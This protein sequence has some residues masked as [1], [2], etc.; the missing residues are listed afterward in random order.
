MKNE[1]KLLYIISG[2]MFILSVSLIMSGC[3]GDATVIPSITPTPTNVPVNTATPVPTSVV[4]TPTPVVIPDISSHFSSNA[5]YD[6]FTDPNTGLR[7]G[8][9]LIQLIQKSS[10]NLSPITEVDIQQE[11][12]PDFVFFG[13]VIIQDG[14]SDLPS[15]WLTTATSSLFEWKGNT[16]LTK[17]F[18]YSFHVNYASAPNLP[19][20]IKVNIGNGNL[21]VSDHGSNNLGYVIIPLVKHD[22]P[23]IIDITPPIIPDNDNIPE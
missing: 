1:K 11:D 7:N 5:Y 3:G 10:S 8:K 18:I 2:L 17:E 20:T 9:F 19:N 12:N 4:N 23:G 14:I 6:T 15:D 22:N 21:T 13:G 16:S